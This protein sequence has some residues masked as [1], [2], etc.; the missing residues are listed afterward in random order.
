MMDICIYIYF[1]IF[2]N[3]DSLQISLLPLEK[4]Q[5]CKKTSDMER[6]G[7]EKVKK[8]ITTLFSKKAISPLCCIFYV[9]GFPCKVE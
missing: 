9:P 6:K 7:P 8:K 5:A 2:R 3:T 4:N 1:F